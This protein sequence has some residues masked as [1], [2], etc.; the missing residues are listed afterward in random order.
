MRK[1]ED[2]AREK[3]ERARARLLSLSNELFT[4]AFRASHR[5]RFRLAFLANGKN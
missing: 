3:E 1:S 5:K 4:S 2:Q